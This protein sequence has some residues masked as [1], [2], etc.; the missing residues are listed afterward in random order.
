LQKRIVDFAADVAF[1]GVSVKLTE[2]YGFEFCPE[3]IRKITLS[4]ANKAGDFMGI[5]Q[6]AS[7]GPG[8]NQLIAESDGGM[9][10][11]VHV[12][13]ALKDKRKN[14]KVCWKE[15][16]LCF[17]REMDKAKGYFR[18]TMK[19]VD[20]LGD[21]WFSSAVAAGLG[22][23]TKIHSLGDGAPWIRDQADR[24]FGTQGSYLVDFYHLSEYLS[25]AATSCSPDKPM[26]WLRTQQIHLKEGNLYLTL[27]ELEKC[28]DDGIETVV[29]CY[30]YMTNRLLQ[31]D[32]LGAILS[33]LPI[34]SG[35]IESGHKHVIQKRLKKAGAWWSE[36]NANSM[37]QLLTLRA[38]DLWGA[39]WA[40]QR[41]FIEKAA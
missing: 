12:E 31:F 26:E 36:E 33:N 16:R 40:E 13:G 32:Y 7:D 9:V 34:G 41:G 28:I 4:H 39:Y 38:N 29:D 24:V 20:D 14:R 27:Q 18:A 15:A 35:E 23:K 17:S 21:M 6:K 3:H 25:A 11:I 8:V 37:L 30:R 1:Q 19:S 2:H 22:N 5:A 10:P